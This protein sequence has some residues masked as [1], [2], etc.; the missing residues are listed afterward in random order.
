MDLLQI[1]S[2]IEYAASLPRAWEAGRDRR[3][4]V[5]TVGLAGRCRESTRADGDEDADVDV[6]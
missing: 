2:Q 6:V 3:V 1:R 5:L 4:S